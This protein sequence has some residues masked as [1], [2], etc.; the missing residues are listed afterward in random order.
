[1][2]AV[3][4]DLIRPGPA[5]ETAAGGAIIALAVSVG[6]VVGNPGFSV[7]PAIVIALAAIASALV[8][9]QTFAGFLVI[10]ASSFIFICVS[11]TSDRYLNTFDFILLFMFP[12]AVFGSLRRDAVVR[13]R[14]LET[15]AAHEKIRAATNRFTKAITIYVGLAALSLVPMAF[16]VGI[17]AATSSAFAVARLI[18]GMLLFP[19]GLWWLTSEQRIRQ[20]FWAAYLGG[21][22]LAVLDL[23]Q[24][25]FVHVE[26]PGIT[27]VVNQPTWPTEDPNQ[28]GLSMVMMMALLFAYQGIRPRLWT[29]LPIVAA[30]IAVLVLSLSRSGIL[31]MCTFLV[32]SLR[33]VRVRHVLG[34]VVV[35]GLGLLLAPEFFWARM[36]RTI[37]LERGSAELF[38]WMIRVV[39]YVSNVRLFLDNW[40]FGT[41]YL[42]SVH[43]SQK[44]NELGIPLVA[45]NF[46]LETAVGMGVI[47]IA[48]MVLCFVR[49]FELGK[50][51]RE[52]APAGTLGHGLARYHTPLLT[53]IML[54]CMFGSLLVGMVLVAQLAMWCALMVR[55]GHEA[56]SRAAER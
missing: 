9:S 55:A 36:Y 20:F 5:R 47:G 34:G 15:G 45:E 25:I 33:G 43:L 12:A 41:G 21:C 18:E 51:V 14:L 52:V 46:Y 48:A 27:W 19:L 53:G 16:R 56:V 30:A 4:R 11:V 38:S 8:L 6:I 54:A 3:L 35:L 29:V 40:L 10:V 32:M 1:M 49:M 42:S 17:E 7:L 50:V 37:T 22:A 2:A 23:V 24:R 13:D 31:A 44:Y 28:G 39:G 26:R